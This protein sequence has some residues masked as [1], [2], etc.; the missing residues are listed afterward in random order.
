M[1]FRSGCGAAIDI[2]QHAACTHCLAPISVLD[3]DAVAKALVHYSEVDARR[4]DPARLAAAI[5]EA[6]LGDT[7]R[8]RVAEAG[9]PYAAKR[10]ETSQTGLPTQDLLF[11]SIGAVIQSLGD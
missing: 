2:K 10:L 6:M 5:A 1:L 9:K 3:P 7:V 8:A 4:K 11:T